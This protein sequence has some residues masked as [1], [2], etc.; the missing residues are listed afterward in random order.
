MSGKK[1]I[2]SYLRIASD[3]LKEASI[4]FEA[5][6]RNSVYLAEQAAEQI[7]L[8]LAESEGIHFGRNLNHQLDRMLARFSDD[9][10]FKSALQRVSWLEAYATTYKYPKASGAIT[11]PPPKERLRGALD[12]LTTILGRVADHFGV[13]LTP[14]SATPAERS[15]APRNG[16]KEGGNGS[17][18]GL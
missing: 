7:I 4:L 2:A 16:R 5:S 6:G 14:G 15:Q 10:T 11:P 18:G 13:D 17:G 12:E 8:S 9:N 3:D 1:L